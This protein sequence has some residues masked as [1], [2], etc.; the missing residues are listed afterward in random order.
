M[1][2]KPIES[3]LFIHLCSAYHSVDWAGT[4]LSFIARRR[5]GDSPSRITAPW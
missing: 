1:D 5:F 2:N 4:Y 3:L